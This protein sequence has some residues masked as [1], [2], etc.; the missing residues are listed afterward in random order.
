[1]P[2][3]EELQ[4]AIEY[5][6]SDK[7]LKGKKILITAGGTQEKIDPVRFISNY[8]TGKMGYALAHECARR[9]AEVYLVHGAVSTTLLN[10]FGLIKSIE[11]LSAKEMYDAC[12]NI[13]P[14]TDCAI[15]CAAVADF[16][17]KQIA[18][19]K[20]K[21]QTGQTEMSL[22]L[23]VTPDIA[24]SLGESKQKGQVLVGFALETSNENENAQTKLM[25]KNMDAIVLNSLRKEGAGFGVDTNCVTMIFAS[26][27]SIELPLQSKAEIANKI[28]N[29]LT[30]D[31]I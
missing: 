31:L 4:E 13:W 2:E 9:G 15:L 6:L 27:N 5:A 26:G 14:K 17:P 30:T 12:M 22:Q 20:I 25:R 18:E 28:L 11:A 10:P 1:M 29:Q 21:K 3:V 16:A 7:S 23:S 8:S 24:R 19:N